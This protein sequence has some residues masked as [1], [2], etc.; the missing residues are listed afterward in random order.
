MT[1]LTDLLR[2]K[3]IEYAIKTKYTWS[4]FAI[5]LLGPNRHGMLY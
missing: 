4:K 1:V 2:K 5:E 3:Y